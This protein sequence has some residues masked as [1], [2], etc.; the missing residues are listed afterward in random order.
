MRMKLLG[1]RTGVQV[2]PLA[3]GTGR[4]GLGPGGDVNLGQARDAIAAYLDAGGNLVDTST[5]YLGGRAEELLGELM[6]GSRREEIVVS[7]KFGRTAVARPAAAAAGQHR[8]ALRQEVEGSLRRLGTDY[9]DV[10]FAHTDD[11]V[12]PMDEL[13]AGLDDLVSAGKILWVGLSSFP[14]WRAAQPS[15]TFAG[16]LP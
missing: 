3:L 8:K 9:I 13:M 11:G 15:P 12:T 10:Y 5:R 2:S 4:L 16:G 7:S 14:A 6:R 1:E